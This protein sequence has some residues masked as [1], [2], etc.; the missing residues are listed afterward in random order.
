MPGNKRL[1]GGSV[2]TRDLH[3]RKLHR[4][5]ASSLTTTDQPLRKMKPSLY[6]LPATLLAATF[7]LTAHADPRI[8]I[9]LGLRLGPPPP[10][11][12]HE[13]PPRPVVVVE[14]ERR[15]AQPGPDYVWVS[16][17]NTYRDGRWVWVGGAW[18]RPPQ[19]GAVYVEGR[20]DRGT[21]NWVDAHWEVAER[22]EFGDR[23]DDRDHDRWDHRGPGGVDIVVEAPP[24]P[25]H[26]H[27]DHRPGPD[28]V[29]IDGYW[30][31]H[32][33]HHEWVAG[34][35]DRPPHGHHEWVAPRWEHRGKGYVFI[36]GSWR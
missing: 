35:W 6:L 15:D 31:W 36:E 10:I 19:P 24:P 5:P 9:D 4:Y 30:A 8:N 12:V 23:H 16:G 2:T 25:R 13:E 28:Y 11:V 21:R 26:E 18:A 3:P 22:H 7:S 14:K 32:G 27:R 17:H 1:F 34:R 29:W 33:G 20:W